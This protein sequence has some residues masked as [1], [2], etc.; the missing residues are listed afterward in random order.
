MNYLL[1]Y[2]YA[3]GFGTQTLFTHCP[4]DAQGVE[5]GS[6]TSPNAKIKIR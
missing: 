1:T 4:R 3:I 6:Q 2:F 5:F